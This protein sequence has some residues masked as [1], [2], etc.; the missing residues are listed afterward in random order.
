MPLMRALLLRGGCVSVPLDVGSGWGA[1]S[2]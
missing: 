1:L 2:R